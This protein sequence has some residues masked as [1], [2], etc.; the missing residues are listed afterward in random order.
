MHQ[1]THHSVVTTKMWKQNK[2][3]TT[4]DWLSKLGSIH[5][6]EH[7]AAINTYNTKML[8]QCGKLMRLNEKSG[9]QNCM[10]IVIIT[11]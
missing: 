8:W 4:W 6:M 3:L 5:S 11:V 9:L 7:S 1:D 2:G 10:Y